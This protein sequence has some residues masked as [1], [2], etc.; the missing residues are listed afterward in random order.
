ML[1]LDPNKQFGKNIPVF[2]EAL[3]NPKAYPH[4]VKNV[5]LME[6]HISWIILTGKYAYKIK[7]DLDFGFFNGTNIKERMRFCKEEIRLNRRLSPH[8]YIGISA[9]LGPPKLAR[10]VDLEDGLLDNKNSQKI[11]HILDYAVKMIEFPQSELIINYIKENLI[12]IYSI[13][14]LAFKLAKF[15]LNVEVASRSNYGNKHQVIKSVQ[16]NLNIL[17]SLNLPKNEAIILEEHQQWV[18]Q[19]YKKLE[20]K[21]NKRLV[22]GAIRECHGDL[23]L[24]NIRINKKSELDV[25]DAIDFNEKLRWIDP[26]SEI[27]FLMMDLSSYALKKESILFLNTWLE[28]TGDYRGLELLKWYSAYRAMVRA[29]VAG[30]RWEQLTKSNIISKASVTKTRC[31]FLSIKKYL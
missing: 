20:G 19:N 7:K 10:V 27:S 15:H 5:V 11:I 23:H 1:L 28:E 31:E 3:M 24:N 17:K 12:P 4:Y 21:F 30:L 29:K 9:I 16:E 13:K 14:R 22:E 8:L 26:I 18:K 2:I 6:T 25:F